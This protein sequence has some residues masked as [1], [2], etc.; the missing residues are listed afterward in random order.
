MAE[1]LI[2]SDHFYVNASFYNDTESDQPATI[3]VEDNDDI[4]RRDTGDE[5]LVHVTRF[6]C[7]SMTTLNY[8]NADTSASWEIIAHNPDG[9]PSKKWNFVLNRN[10]ATP[11]DLISAMNIRNRFVAT[12]TIE[13]YRFQLDPGGRFHLSMHEYPDVDS[14]GWYITYK[15]TAAMNSL[16]GFEQLTPFLSFAPDPAHRFCRALEF[17]EQE[18]NRVN[19][20]WNVES[21]DFHTDTNRCLVELMNGLEVKNV[22]ATGH[23]HEGREPHNVAHLLMDTVNWQNQLNN[24]EFKPSWKG[25]TPHEES[26]QANQA[27]LPRDGVTV[28]CQYYTRRSNWESPPPQ[29]NVIGDPRDIGPKVTCTRLDYQSGHQY[30]GNANG[31]AEGVVQFSDITHAPENTTRQTP[32]H[33]PIYKSGSVEW[34]NSKYVYPLDSIPG[35]WYAGSQAYPHADCVAIANLQVPT[36]FPGHDHKTFE[37]HRALPDFVEVGHDM[38]I[39]DHCTTPNIDIAGVA[40]VHGVEYINSDRTIVSIDWAF[41]RHMPNASHDLIF[42]DRRIPY[43]TR[44]QSFESIVSVTV[45]GDTKVI[46]TQQQTPASVGDYVTFFGDPLQPGWTI[47]YKRARPRYEILAID[48]SSDSKSFTITADSE[49]QAGATQHFFIDKSKWDKIRWAQDTV[50]MKRAA[51]TY[52][53]HNHAQKTTAHIAAHE[54]SGV[55]YNDSYFQLYDKTLLAQQVDGFNKQLRRSKIFKDGAASFAAVTETF[56]VDDAL[57]KTIPEESQ[58]IVD[59]R[60][61]DFLARDVRTVGYPPAYQLPDIM[62]RMGIGTRPAE[63]MDRFPSPWYSIRM[64]ETTHGDSPDNLERVRVNDFLETHPNDK[65]HMHMYESPTL[66]SDHLYFFGYPADP[67]RN[68]SPIITGIANRAGY[69]VKP[70][71]SGEP[72]FERNLVIWAPPLYNNTQPMNSPAVLDAM[73]STALHATFGISYSNETEAYQL[74]KKEHSTVSLTAGSQTRLYGK[75]GDYIASAKQSHIDRIFP[76]RQ[77]ILTSDD[78]MQVPERSQDAASK[79]PVLSSYTLPTMGSTSVDA[80]GNP[81]GGSSKPFGTIYFSEGGSRRFHHMIKVPGGLRRFKIN[82]ALTYKDHSQP[83]KEVT[84]APGGQFTCQ[85]MFMKKAKPPAPAPTPT[86]QQSVFSGNL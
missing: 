79:Q 48:L 83:A 58:E 78:L 47:D 27:L 29:T 51:T 4:L 28:M 60:G 40:H 3:M 21:G 68:V 22:F 86:P 46:V 7:D 39:V 2:A 77:L 30:A 33:Y 16:L 80:E 23:A 31:S 25:V 82:A 69:R 52:I 67:V 50:R 49:V 38:W 56:E 20:I 57:L 65:P 62:Q 63:L 10:Y 84:L 5:W 35:Y 59:V 32:A 19:T 17:F 45:V 54:A 1:A 8:I 9:A 12:G 76:W 66:T 11:R 34:T 55:Q 43:Q 64:Y 37:L 24:F 72:F 74:C 36:G 14:R 70:A 13:A 42:T 41:G 75:D 73:T 81:S 18:C 53:Y 44:S 6:S 85:L 15:G 26:T 61:V 71:G